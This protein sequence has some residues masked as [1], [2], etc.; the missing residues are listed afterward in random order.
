MKLHEIAELH[1]KTGKEIKF[2]DN[3][4][5]YE[6]KHEHL[7]IRGNNI[8]INSVRDLLKN[9]YEIVQDLPEI[10]P[11]PFCGN[12]PYVKRGNCHGADVIYEVGCLSCRFHFSR[13]YDAEDE[14]LKVW[15]RRV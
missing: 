2:H 14:A 10:K 15:N 8:P 5:V 1:L 13:I 7:F 4:I 6:F 12:P 9:N 3:I 11:C